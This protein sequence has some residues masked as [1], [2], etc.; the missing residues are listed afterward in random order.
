[1]IKLQADGCTWELFWAGSS[2]RG[3][4]SA[5]LPR[6]P[7]ALSSRAFGVPGQGPHLAG[8]V[9][10]LVQLQV[11]ANLAAQVHPLALEPLD[12]RRFQEAGPGH[13]G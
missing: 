5:L 12:H 13:T 10:A 7:L 9:V 11:L 4:S 3:F 8:S 1:M 6:P 2:W